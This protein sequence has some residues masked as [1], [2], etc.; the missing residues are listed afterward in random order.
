MAIPFFEVVTLCRIL[1][2]SMTTNTSIVDCNL[3]FFLTQPPT[4]E[5]YIFYSFYT[6]YILNKN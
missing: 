5:Q 6:L 3:T 4:C 1:A 2:L